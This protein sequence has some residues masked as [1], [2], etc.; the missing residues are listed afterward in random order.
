MSLI[1]FFSLFKGIKLPE[2]SENSSHIIVEIMIQEKEW[3]GG[4]VEG[5]YIP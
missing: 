4:N 3:C 2:F 5:I 1:F